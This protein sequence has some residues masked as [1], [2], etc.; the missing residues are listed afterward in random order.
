MNPSA[1][2]TENKETAAQNQN[3]EKKPS[4]TVKPLFRI[5]SVAPYLNEPVCQQ[6]C[7]R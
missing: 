4:S 7:I 1:S 2:K 3:T 6:N 5:K